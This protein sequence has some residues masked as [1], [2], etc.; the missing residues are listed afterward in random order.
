M[1]TRVPGASSLKSMEVPLNSWDPFG[2]PGLSFRP[3]HGTRECRQNWPEQSHDEAY[4]SDCPPHGRPSCERFLRKPCRVWSSPRAVPF[5]AEHFCERDLAASRGAVEGNVRKLSAGRAAASPP[6]IMN[7]R[8]ITLRAGNV[9][10]QGEQNEEMACM[11]VNLP[12]GGVG[13]VHPVSGAAL[14]PE[15]LTIYL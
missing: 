15:L 10:G 5:D 2:K 1:S 7:E 3:G 13:L 12:R 8:I 6:G 4:Q 9:N 11:M 14:R